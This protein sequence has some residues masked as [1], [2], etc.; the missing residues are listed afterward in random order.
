MNSICHFFKPKIMPKR[1]LEI[2]LRGNYLYAKYDA[3]LKERSGLRAAIHNENFYS[4]EGQKTTTFCH[5]NFSIADKT[6]D[7]SLFLETEKDWGKIF[8][9]DRSLGR[10]P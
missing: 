9:K 1:A 5:Q 3:V 7:L 10:P 8:G 6:E 4:N 2:S